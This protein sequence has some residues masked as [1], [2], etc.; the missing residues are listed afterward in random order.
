[1]PVED[2]AAIFSAGVALVGLAWENIWVRRRISSA[3]R[4]SDYRSSV[5][6]P[7]EVFEKAISDIVIEVDDWRL[8]RG[9]LSEISLRRNWTKISRDLNRLLNKLAA[10]T[11]FQPKDGWFEVST[12]EVDNAFATIS[13]EHRQLTCTTTIRCL[14]RLGESIAN[15][16]S[17]IRP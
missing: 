4:I 1:L 17:E 2:F 16:L 14:E 13:E 11:K 5:E 15:A 7:L 3:E 6:Q 9:D 12:E 10:S 8:A